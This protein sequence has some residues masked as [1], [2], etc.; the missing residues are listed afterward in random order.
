MK[1]ILLIILV[2]G[3]TAC[4]SHQ[5]SAPVQDINL[6]RS[7]KMLVHHVQ[8]GETL[9]AVAALLLGSNWQG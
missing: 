6:H 8:R 3:L 7:G 9:Y 1:K 4:V 5:S 2:M